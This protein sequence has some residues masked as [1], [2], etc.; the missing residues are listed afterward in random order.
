MP[1]NLR[2]ALD[3]RTV[4]CFHIEARWPGARDHYIG[5]VVTRQVVQPSQDLGF[6]DLASY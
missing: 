2:S 1:A 5:T 3:A 4:L 6:G